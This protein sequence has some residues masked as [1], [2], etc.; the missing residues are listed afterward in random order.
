[1]KN[2]FRGLFDKRELIRAIGST[3]GKINL[4]QFLDVLIKINGKMTKG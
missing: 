3:K 4:G 2:Y 1:M